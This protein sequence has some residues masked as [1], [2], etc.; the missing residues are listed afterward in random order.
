MDT[1]E[2]A[3]LKASY[4]AKGYHFPLAVMTSEE[5]DELRAAYE[6][7]E[8]RAAEEPAVAS[9]IKTYVQMVLPFIDRMIRLPAIL[10]PVEALLGPDLLVYSAEFFIKEPETEAYV[11]WHQDLHY[12]G[13]AQD[14]EVT[15][16]VALSPA[17]VESGCMRYLP[18]SHRQHYDHSDSFAED[19]MLTRGQEV[20][21]GAEESKAVDVLLNPGQMSLHHG[22]TLHA[23]RPNRSKDR[24]MG[25]VIRYIATSMRQAGGERPVASLVRGEDRYGHFKLVAPPRGLL[26][27]LDIEHQQA[28]NAVSEQIVF[29]GSTRGPRHERAVGF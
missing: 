5:A 6:A 10:D 25:L 4:A 29:R 3:R 26:D 22:R 23:S 27:P 24:R 13:L 11:S 8:A 14:D 9:A 19:N 20:A 2:R 17:T 1:E 12:W 21:L 7:L 16:W 18:G 28:A 15:A